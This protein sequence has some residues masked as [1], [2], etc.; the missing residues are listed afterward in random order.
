MVPHRY[1]GRIRLCVLALAVSLALLGVLR[2][3]VQARADEPPHHDVVVLL[4]NSG[5]MVRSYLKDKKSGK[6]TPKT[7]YDIEQKRIRFA[8]LLVRTLQTVAPEGQSVGVALFAAEVKGADPLPS[9]V[10]LVSLTPVQEWTTANLAAIR[11]R[12]CPPHDAVDQDGNP[13]AQEKDRDFCYGTSYS[14]ALQW[15]GEQLTAQ[16]DCHTSDHRCDILLFTDG[17]IEEPNSDV[18]TDVREALSARQADGISVSAVLF[19]EDG[20]DP[21]DLEN[22]QDWQSEGWV[23]GII[24][25]ATDQQPQDLY[26]AV[27]GLLGL[28]KLLADFILVESPLESRW[29]ATGSLPPNLKSLKLD[30]LTDSPLIDS[31]DPPADI[32]SGAERWW[33]APGFDVLTMKWSGEGVAYYRA[34]SQTVPLQARVAVLPAVQVMGRPVEVQALVHAA[35]RVISDESKL[36]VHAQIQPGGDELDLSPQPDGAWTGTSQGLG[37]GDYVVT[38]LIEPKGWQMSAPPEIVSAALQVR[39]AR[40]QNAILRV[41]PERQWAGQPVEFEVTLFSDGLLTELLPGSLVTVTLQPVGESYPL[42]QQ[43]EGIWRATQPITIAGDY[44]ANVTIQAP[45]WEASPVPASLEVLALPEV[46][47]STAQSEAAPGEEITATVEVSA[48]EPLTPTLWR[49]SGQDRQPVELQPLGA[50]RFQ[51]HAEMPE[52][53]DL[54]LVA[55]LPDWGRTERVHKLPIDPVAIA[56]VRG[57]AIGAW[58]MWLRRTILSGAVLGG[59]ALMIVLGLVVSGVRQVYVLGR[60]C[61]KALGGDLD[62]LGKTLESAQARHPEIRTRLARALATCPQMTERQV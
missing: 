36:S 43:P 19:A 30:V 31:Y 56:V 58:P 51:G 28:E 25:D 17:L 37:L 15:A 34:V 16:G 33:L 39:E 44:A 29:P 61:G 6:V 23:Y 7:P 3:F 57:K 21:R 24:A 52:T 35:G 62:A 50:G 13:V 14:A 48:T 55:N 60:D 41:W 40:Q 12:E 47:V 5:S 8:R 38:V 27:F 54:T 9:T 10:P 22:W 2:G 4:D 53:G 32:Q 1:A 20:Q 11:P 26:P 42:L 45:G 46:W 49:Q 18:I 59:L